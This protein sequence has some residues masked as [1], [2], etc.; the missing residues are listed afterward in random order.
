MI[1]LPF[2]A[3]RSSFL[4]LPWLWKSAALTSSSQ[5]SCPSPARPFEVIL[6]ERKTLV[7]KPCQAPHQ[8]Q[9]VWNEYAFSTVQLPAALTVRGSVSW[10]LNGSFREQTGYRQRQIGNKSF[11]RNC[12]FKKEEKKERKKSGNWWEGKSNLPLGNA[13]SR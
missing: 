11:T 12:G 4:R 2:Y 13:A 9:R 7:H 3:S 5:S 8:C 1:Y 10:N 6:A